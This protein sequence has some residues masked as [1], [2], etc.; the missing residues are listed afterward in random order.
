MRASAFSL[1]SN[2]FE[3]RG[4]G[5]G[6]PTLLWGCGGG[7]E[8]MTLRAEWL[9]RPL[10][11]CCFC[12]FVPKLCSSWT[13]CWKLSPV[14]AGSAVCLSSC[15]TD[16]MTSFNAVGLVGE[17]QHSLW[18]NTAELQ[19]ASVVFFF[20]STWLFETRQESPFK[21]S[22]L[23]SLCSRPWKEENAFQMSLCY[24]AAHLIVFKEGSFPALSLNP[25]HSFPFSDKTRR[26]IWN[27][28]QEITTKTTERIF[29]N[30]EKPNSHTQFQD[31]RGLREKCVKISLQSA[32]QLEVQLE[33]FC[34]IQRIYSSII[35]TVM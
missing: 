4:I 33:T 29:E 7:G 26:M 25:H 12:F 27:S 31:R 19:Q 24:K 15:W 11:G 35:H 13:V 1:F 23:W 3:K 10:W 34:P 28:C 20:S 8:G 16:P 5:L 32:R 6:P 22:L 17:L 30:L 18:G 14:P 9:D 21:H 2:T